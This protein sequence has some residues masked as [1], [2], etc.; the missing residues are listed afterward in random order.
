MRFNKGQEVI[1]IADIEEWSPILNDAVRQVDILL[2]NISTPK[3]NNVYIVENPMEL[4]YEGINY[5]KIE[6]FDMPLSEKAF[7]PNIKLED[8]SIEY[9]KLYN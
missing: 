4:L 7:M 3:K 1:C 9:E 2:G 6:G 8:R 5:I